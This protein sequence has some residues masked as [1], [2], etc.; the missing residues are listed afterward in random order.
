M[1]S[2]LIALLGRPSSG[3]SS[4]LNSLCG[5]KIAIVASSP[6]TTR[7]TV[8]G[9][10]TEERGQL[11]FLDTPGFHV[12]R[13]KINRHLRRL[14]ESTV[15]ESDSIL[16][17]VDSYRKIGEE[18]EALIRLVSESGK[19]AIIALNKTDLGTRRLEQFG[20]IFSEKLPDASVYPVS[21]KTGFGMKDLKTGLYLAAPEGELMYPE[22]YYTDQDPEF[23]ISEIIREQVV[24]RTREELPHAVYVEIQDTEFSQQGDSL[25]VRA[26]IFVERE[27]QKGIIV[28]KGGELIKRVRVESEKALAELFPYRVKLDLRVKTAPH[29][30]KDDFLLRRLIH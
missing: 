13:K 26:S 17:V 23:R 10:L 30:H 15:D 16:Y 1:K 18:E 14:A 29:W 24:T 3:K 19:P 25:W 22:E 4:I 21:A 2:A 28:G 12:S 9:I 27:S 7:N 20:R 11:V 6:Q 8:R 5:H